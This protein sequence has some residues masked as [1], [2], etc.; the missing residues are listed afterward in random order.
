MASGYEWTG[1]ELNG[2][3]EDYAG[4]ALALSADGLV[5]AVGAHNADP[6]DGNGGTINN[7]G[8]VVIREWSA[9]AAEWVARAVVNGEVAHD[10]TG[11]AIA[12]SADG[13]VLAIGEANHDSNNAGRVRVFDWDAM[14]DAYVVRDDPN[15]KLW[16]DA[17]ADQAGHSV[18]L[19]A[20]GAVVAMGML[21]YASERG[22]VRVFAWDAGAGTWTRRGDDGQLDG[23]AGSDFHGYSVA[24]SD[25]GTVLAVGASGYDPPGVANGGLARVHKWDG[26]AWQQRG[27]DIPGNENDD[28]LG[29]A[30][31]LSADGTVLAVGDRMYGVG[32][33][34]HD[35]RGRVTV[36]EYNAGNDHWDDR[37]E[38]ILGE[39]NSDRGGYALQLS[40]DGTVIVAG[41]KHNDPPDGSGG[42]LGNGG[43]ARV[44]AYDAGSDEWHKVGVDLDGQAASGWH[45]Y[46]VGISADATVVAVSAHEY[47]STQGSMRVYTLQSN[48][49][50][51]VGNPYFTSA[52]AITTNAD[53]PDGAGF[54]IAHSSNH[55]GEG[56]NAFRHPITGANQWGWTSG[57]TTNDEWVSITY[58]EP[59]LL[60]RYVF[61]GRDND[62]F[63]PK[64]WVMEGSND[65]GNTWTAIGTTQTPDYS[66]WVARQVTEVDV[67]FNTVEYSSFRVFCPYVDTTL[68]SIGYI[69][70]FTAVPAPSPPAPPSAPPPPPFYQMAS[71]YALTTTFVGDNEK[72]HFGKWVAMSA[73]GTVV[74]V[75]AYLDDGP[76]GNDNEMGV[77]RTFAWDGAVWNPMG[78]RLYGDAAG[79]EHGYRLDLSAD[80]TI[81][82]IG[83]YNKYA[84]VHKWNPG[85]QQWDP[86]GNRINEGAS[87]TD[88]GLGNAVALSNDGAVLAVG[89]QSADFGGGAVGTVRVFDW[90]DDNQDWDLRADPVNALA[91]DQVN[92]IHASAVSISGSGNVLAIGAG[93]GTN[94]DGA[95]YAGYVR[96]FAWN[97]DTQQWDQQAATP[98]NNI[99][100]DVTWD[101][102]GERGLALSDDG[103]VLAI[104]ATGND[105]AGNSGGHLRVYM[106]DD[107]L[108]R[109]SQRGA[110]I[111][112]EAVSQLGRS[113]DLSAD[114]SILAAGAFSYDDYRGRVKVY[115]WDGGAYTQVGISLDGADKDHQGQSV[116]LSDD[117]QALIVGAYQYAPAHSS[118]TYTGLAR[119]YNLQ[120][121]AQPLVGNPY[122]T[123][124]TTITT[125][126]DWP[127]GAGFA[128]A[129]SS[130]N[131][132]TYTGWQAFRDPV[133]AFGDNEYG[134]ISDPAGSTIDEWVTITYPEPVL[135]Q[136]YVLTA[137]P[138]PSFHPPSWQIQGSNDGGTTWTD[139]GA[140][141]IP[142][143][144][145]VE[146]QV[147]QVDVSFNTVEYATYQVLC[148]NAANQGKDGHRAI[149]YIRLFTAVPLPQPPP[150]PSAPLSPPAPLGPPP[151]PFY[152]IANGYSQIGQTLDG[153]RAKARSGH[154]VATNADGTIV[155]TS[156]YQD[157][158]PDGNLDRGMVRVWA[159][160]GGTSLWEPMGQRLYG[161]DWESNGYGMV[162][163]P[164]GTTLAM[165]GWNNH[166][167]VR[168][169]NPAGA[170][171]WDLLG[172]RL[173]AQSGAQ[174][175]GFGSAVGLSDDGT[176]L[177][178]GCRNAAFSGTVSGTVQVYDL[179][180][181]TWNLRAD[182]GNMLR[183][184]DTNG[185]AGDT[186]SLS[187]SGNILA[188]SM[189]FATNNDGDAYAGE[190]RVF[191]WNGASW[192]QQSGIPHDDI[193][194]EAT[195]DMNQAVSLSKDGTILAIGAIG[196]DGDDYPDSSQRGHARVWAYDGTHWSQR[197][198]DLDGVNP[199]DNFGASV[200][201]SGDGNVLAVGAENFDG[202]DY[203][204]DT[205]RGHVRVFAW[206]GTTYARV[207]DD[208]VGDVM[209]N[210]GRSM[211]LSSDGHVLVVGA[212]QYGHVSPDNRA[213]WSRVYEV[214]FDPSSPLPPALPPSPPPPP[215][216]PPSP[217]VW[218]KWQ[219]VPQMADGAGALCVRPSPL[220]QPPPPPPAPPVA[221]P[222]PAPPSLPPPPVAPPP[223]MPPPPPVYQ[224][225]SHYALSAT[226]PGEAHSVS[227]S[228]DGTRIAFGPHYDC[229]DDDGHCA[230]PNG[231]WRVVELTSG[232]QWV[233]AGYLPADS[234][235]LA[236]YGDSIALSRDG[237]VVAVW[238]RPASGGDPYTLRV[239]EVTSGSN[240]WQQRGQ[241]LT[242][243][244]FAHAA[245]STDG[246]ILAYGNNAAITGEQGVVR[247]YQYDPSA[248]GGAG[249]WGQIGQDMTVPSGTG[250]Q[251]YGERVAL[252]ADGFTVFA[253]A[254][255]H[256][257]P[258]SNTG[259]AMV[260]TY[261]ANAD[262]W[263]LKGNA[264]YGPQSSYQG[265]GHAGVTMSA[266]GTR[267]AMGRMWTG[268]GEV[269]VLDYNASSNTWEPVGPPVT[270]S[271]T[272]TAYGSLV[273]LSA[274]GHTL[275]VAHGPHNMNSQKRIEVLVYDGAAW[276]MIGLDGP[277]VGEF[278][279]T[280]DDG[281][282]IAVPEEGYA[283]GNVR[284]YDA[285]AHPSPSPPPP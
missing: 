176:V 35:E 93:Y 55:N 204:T 178:V 99:G 276:T 140:L 257:G 16:G 132:A 122:F 214:Q 253:N 186:L 24:L 216:P 240:P 51:L 89:C 234:T 229:A 75:G 109:W 103:K 159:W 108:E 98:H 66:P 76:N 118:L 63:Y 65:G 33:P 137:G 160:N 269:A 278:V 219:D 259:I 45:G 249:Q 80:G 221:P 260:H 107:A 102:L 64:E 164:D 57:S 69:R 172:N 183:G 285:V 133:F 282:R 52:T 181:N 79:S 12:L 213:G 34:N 110:D 161:N 97:S 244:N 22:V 94:E 208:I 246:S 56:W 144:V 60:Q 211:A 17:G 241:T 243:S 96:V 155:A 92:M 88:N 168:R 147:T 13:A 166:V 170:G 100:G 3:P 141:Q 126:T 91:G 223:P 209:D 23:E 119:I 232:G 267:V 85:T 150:P 273:Q 47:P 231:E 268:D 272:A 29:V 30:V 113:V 90:N 280:N 261:D 271:G 277:V 125:N 270:G 266:D 226:I 228:A 149:R 182:P 127:D 254:A 6:P 154:R 194:G 274:D 82:V 136:R 53:W 74:A 239:F 120:Y 189:P 18:A 247:V 2:D 197:G 251:Y 37:G 39:A 262:T 81:L 114:G 190:V 283:G 201:L 101:M 148:P 205:W 95:T 187:G 193:G 152:E 31:D 202:D 138:E 142:D 258:Q 4:Y 175:D 281:S 163:T 191:E 19:S 61:T 77:V 275:I 235:I 184:T 222:S 27:Q 41:A 135:L 54:A 32:D 236:Q 256:D 7:A 67:S 58:P 264:I 169:W 131:P 196:N 112:G 199:N 263:N 206:D 203:P 46:A 171:S 192:D 42:T 162:L 105:A 49:M 83:S 224:T 106:Y 20:D 200:A 59:V 265:D 233:N 195:W 153:E 111:N 179:S 21:G 242:D 26:A 48:A 121:N 173:S 185:Y 248:N 165:T 167:E 177:A 220:P 70:L 215:P 1:Q 25:D 129:H 78:Q 5:L 250:R 217:L 255:Y 84:E 245:L 8:R 174:D 14:G 87:A 62:Q 9:Q 15:S 252:S 115:A 225:R 145:W 72:A 139:I 207:G 10:N 238:G 157:D 130:F 146:H 237:A 40:A 212:Y 123:S 124:A 158:G 134:W 71:G 44:W 230:G 210:V 151:P 156:A 279:A 284:I 50:A 86:R 180:G 36:Y 11:R 143:P 68:R 28:N 128:V 116:A 198:G 218:G 188:F 38:P 227:M 73:D 104:G 43:H 117:G